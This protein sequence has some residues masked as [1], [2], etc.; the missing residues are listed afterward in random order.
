M[1]P[2]TIGLSNERYQALLK[3]GVELFNLSRTLMLPC[4]TCGSQ[5]ME[6]N[7][8][9]Y[10]GI[11]EACFTKKS[12]L[13]HVEHSSKKSM[14]ERSEKWLQICP[15]LY[16]SADLSFIDADKFT[17]VTRWNYNPI[18]LMLTGASRQGKTTSCWHL[19]HKLY[20]LQS[21]SFFALSEPE[22]SILRERSTRNGSL[23]NFLNRC[24]SCSVFFLDDIGHAATTAKHMEELYFIVEKRSSWKKPIICTT[25]FSTN[26]IEERS[27]R[28]GTSKTAMAILNRLKSFCSPIIF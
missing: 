5:V 15:E 23:D 4:K 10:S 3:E 14:E 6:M 11:C 24:L 9:F 19:L 27:S 28:S 18:G 22:F 21:H 13:F 7:Y 26:E 8:K 16:R 25:Q 2:Q 17:K 20:V 12:L 1:N